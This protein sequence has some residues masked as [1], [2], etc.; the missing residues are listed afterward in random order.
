ML[1]I[2][3][4]IVKKSILSFLLIAL[5]SSVFAQDTIKPVTSKTFMALAV[6][7]GLEKM[8]LHPVQAKKV[9]D[10]NALFVGKC[11][12][13]EGVRAAFSKYGARVN[14]NDAAYQSVAG[15]D[16]A[17]K[18]VRLQALEKLVGQFVDDYYVNH[19]Y[20]ATARDAMQQQLE[21]NAAKNKQMANVKYCASCT[22][23]CK[24]P[25]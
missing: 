16:Q 20:S 6:S 23:S 18:E 9:A 19:K 15:F 4:G 1:T 13:C 22:G 5:I 10:D 8:Q 24:K 11:N 17:D 21:K 12:I 2:N 7:E 3:V 25:G 14:Q